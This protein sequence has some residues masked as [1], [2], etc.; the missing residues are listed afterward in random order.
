M[1]NGD[2][3]EIISI[4][5]QGRKNNTNEWA[6]DPISSPIVFRISG[7]I[8]DKATLHQIIIVFN[9]FISISSR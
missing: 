2:P 9:I 3:V 4:R 5:I 1:E 6:V 8:E 7:Q